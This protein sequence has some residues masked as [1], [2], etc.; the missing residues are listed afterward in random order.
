MGGGYWKALGFGDTFSRP[1]GSNNRETK[2]DVQVRWY[3]PA[4]LTLG[5]VVHLGFRS[6]EWSVCAAGGGFRS[7]GAV[8]G[9]EGR[10][11]RDEDKAVDVCPG[12]SA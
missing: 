7:S 3:G 12:I 8:L 6:S 4:S 11:Y 5:G 10:P 9:E 1:G 2:V